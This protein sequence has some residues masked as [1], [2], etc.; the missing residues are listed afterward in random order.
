ME[1]CDAIFSKDIVKTA[2]FLPCFD[3]CP[4][5]FHSAGLGNGV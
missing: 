1:L 3:G 5:S 2:L 4:A